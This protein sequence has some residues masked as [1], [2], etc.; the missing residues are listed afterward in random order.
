MTCRGGRSLVARASGPSHFLR[1]PKAPWSSLRY[2]MCPFQVPFRM[3]L[4][5]RP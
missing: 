2:S 4:I 5:A 1:N 3:A